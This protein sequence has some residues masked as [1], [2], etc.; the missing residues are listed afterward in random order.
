[1]QQTATKKCVGKVIHWELCKRVKFDHT[2][3][4]YMY[5]PDSIQENETQNSL[6][7]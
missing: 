4:W 3:T 5:K 7:F 6:R 2:S 1:M